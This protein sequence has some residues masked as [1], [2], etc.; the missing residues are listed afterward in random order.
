MS[1]KDTWLSSK[2]ITTSF[3]FSLFS[4]FSKEPLCLQKHFSYASHGILAS[5]LPV[6]THATQNHIPLRKYHVLFR[7]FLWA[8]FKSWLSNYFTNSVYLSPKLC[9]YENYT[10][11][12][13]PKNRNNS[14]FN[15]NYCLKRNFQVFYK[16]TM[17]NFHY[18]T[19]KVLLKSFVWLCSDISL[20]SGDIIQLQIEMKFS[21]KGERVPYVIMYVCMYVCVHVYKI[22]S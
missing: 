1:G 13:F 7:T 2:N 19:K 17:R 8:F 12:Y 6:Y 16:S 5:W 21:E 14:S 3:S 11:I 20:L 4:V 10:F 9:L 18:K 22:D 15:K